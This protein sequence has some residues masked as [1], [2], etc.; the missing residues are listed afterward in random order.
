MPHW[1]P[2]S[3]RGKWYYWFALLALFN[4]ATIIATL[5]LG[6]KVLD[7]YV[8][9]IDYHGQID[10]LLK[11]SSRL[12]GFAARVN[13]PGNDAF[14]SNDIAAERVRLDRSL[15]EFLAAQQSI[16]PA[17]PQYFD[18]RTQRQILG[19]LDHIVAQV[20]QVAAFANQIFS[21]LGAGRTVPAGD[22]MARMDLTFA[23]ALEQINQLNDIIRTF[24]AKR[25]DDQLDQAQVYEQYKSAIGLAVVLVVVLAIVSG[26][27]LSSAMTASQ[28]AVAHSETRLR[29]VLEAAVDAIIAIDERGIILSC[30]AA[31]EKIFGYPIE[32]L[33]GRNISILMSPPDANRHDGYLRNYLATGQ[34]SVIGIGREVVAL[35]AD[36]SQLPIE[37]SV[38]EG[39]VLGKRFFLGIARDIS[40]RQESE[41]QL[42]QTQAQLQVMHDCSPLGMY[43][44]DASGACI[45]VNRMYEVI[46]GGANDAA[47]G[48]G[49]ASRLHPEDRQ[50]VCDD[51]DRAAAEGTPYE[52]IHR[53]LH[54]D[55]KIVW[56]SVKAAPIRNDNELLG[57][58]GVVADISA[59]RQAEEE[60][61]QYNERLQVISRDIKTQAEELCVAQASLEEQNITLQF[62]AE[63]LQSA[64]LQAED[65]NASKSA[66]LANMSHEIRSPM[67][68]ILGFAEVLHQRLTDPELVDAAAT[69]RRN[70]EHLL[71]IIND[72]LDISKI[73][74]GKVDIELLP[75]PIGPLI[76][77]ID[78][79]L[80]LRAKSKGISLSVEIAGPSPATIR[81]DPTRLRQILM[82]LVGNA[83]KFTES[84]AVRLLAE[85]VPGDDPQ[86]RFT[87]EDTGIGITPEQLERL[88]KPFS[89]ADSS[90]TRRFGGT[91]LGLTI[92]KRLAEMLSGTIAVDSQPGRGSRFHLTIPTGDL[93][94]VPFVDRPLAPAGETS[95][96][97]PADQQ[98]PALDCRILLA[99]DGPDNQRLISLFLHKAGASVEVAPNGQLA[100]EA[101]WAAEQQ[102]SPFACV[103]MD[104]Q[105]PVLDGYDAV[106]ALRQE[107]YRRPIVALTAHAM[108]GEREKCLAAGCDAYLT[109][110][111]RRADLLHAVAQFTSGHGQPT[112]IASSPGA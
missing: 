35:R 44:T 39:A 41:R 73:E 7:L 75:T 21:D 25:L 15:A 43:M 112:P 78:D 79:V 77:D 76:R 60:L 30:N 91:G 42:R 103:L 28:R 36:G 34:R 55:G 67:T 101:A 95:A 96:V 72:I 88:F 58:V 71:E 56:T 13:A 32:Q 20:R 48:D 16:R 66:F 38:S 109:K 17:I 87:V 86:M 57:Y 22:N 81:T 11:R 26:K 37:L 65:A 69:I 12:A 3:R 62:Q 97:S 27:R 92:S 110:P 59:S 64:R 68:A 51:W 5:A 18:L 23:Q 4:L 94:G 106:R 74:A 89:Q 102:G 98:L 40:A 105:M 14:R 99:E 49:W 108:Q 85:F 1:S 82:N 47:Q 70:G 6:H 2:P 9:S 10:N 50:R 100:V 80:H 83:I 19:A 29:A 61:R 52:S 111:I 33:V 31:A 90:T 8:N 24:R 63:Q 45:R 84:G 93:N 107:G 104:M 53:F 54:P 46:S